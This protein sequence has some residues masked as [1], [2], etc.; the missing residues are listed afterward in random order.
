MKMSEFR[1]KFGS[2]LDAGMLE[3]ISERLEDFGAGTSAGDEPS[4]TAE[5]DVPTVVRTTRRSRAVSSCL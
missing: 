5:D 1:N 2:D 4:T 3:E